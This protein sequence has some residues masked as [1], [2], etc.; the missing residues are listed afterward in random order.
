MDISVK[1]TMSKIKK[2]V[3]YIP[4]LWKDEDWDFVSILA[5]LEFKINRVAKTVRKNNHI[6]DEEIKEMEKTIGATVEAILNYQD[7]NQ[8]RFP[9]EDLYDVLNVGHRFIPATD[10]NGDEKPRLSSLISVYKGTDT[11]IKSTH[12]RMISSQIK[13]RMKFEQDNWNNIWDT[14]KEHGQS[15]GD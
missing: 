8:D 13:R 2:I 12:K 3:E 4:L 9:E 15:W 6:A 10:D 14:I 1:R 7:T 11:E 5:M